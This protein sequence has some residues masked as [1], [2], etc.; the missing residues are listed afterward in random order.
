[1]VGIEEV[2]DTDEAFGAADRMKMKKDL[3]LFREMLLKRKN[4]K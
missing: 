4:Y 3:G 2:E 1:M